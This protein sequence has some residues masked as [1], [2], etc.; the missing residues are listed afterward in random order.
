MISERTQAINGGK[1][2]R[3]RNKGEFHIDLQATA[4]DDAHRRA[5]GKF[6]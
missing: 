1:A 6:L 4:Q 2:W 3:T 5:K